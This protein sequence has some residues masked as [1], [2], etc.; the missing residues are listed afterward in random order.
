MRVQQQHTYLYNI[1]VCLHP[2]DFRCYRVRMPVFCHQPAD[3]FLYTRMWLLIRPLLYQQY[4]SVGQLYHY[5][6]KQNNNENKGCI[7]IIE[8]N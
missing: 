5:N 7:F 2:N 1:S 8:L 4:R 6:L 3:S